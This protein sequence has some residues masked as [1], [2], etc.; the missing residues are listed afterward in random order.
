MNSLVSLQ[1]GTAA[2]LPEV[3]ATMN[4]AFDRRFG[5]AWT[6]SQCSGILLL[7]GVW[8]TLARIGGAPA[9]FALNRI[10][11][12]EAELLLL[13]VRPGYRRTGVGQALLANSVAVSASRGAA[14]IHLEVRDGNPAIAL[15]NRADFLQSGRRRQYYS[16]S[17]G[18]SFDAL[19]LSRDLRE[20]A[21]R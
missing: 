1:P 10:I 11:V 14:R 9:G 5:E 12:D 20:L 3:M 16:G 13:A 4:E 15:Y 19:T 17:D 8:L 21:D 7:A 2:D 18:R 6:N